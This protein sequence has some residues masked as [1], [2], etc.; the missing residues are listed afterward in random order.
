MLG[1][2]ALCSPLVTAVNAPELDAVGLKSS[3]VEKY[4][5][6][7]HTAIEGVGLREIAEETLMR[8]L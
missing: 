4:F 3:F 7:T 6:G 8:R 5:T 2:K 1:G